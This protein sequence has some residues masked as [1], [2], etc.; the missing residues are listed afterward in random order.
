[1]ADVSSNNTRF[2]PV[3]YAGAG[4]RRIAIKATQSAGYTNPDHAVWTHLAHAARLSVTHY[5]WYSPNANT[6]AQYANLAKAILPVFLPGDSIAIDVEEPRYNKEPEV[7]YSVPLNTL[8][9]AIV[10][11][12]KHN[13]IIYMDEDWYT[14]VGIYVKT[15]EGRMWIAGYGPESPT[16]IDGHRLWAWQNTDGQ[17]GPGPHVTAGVGRCDCSL[18]NRRT[19]LADELRYRMRRS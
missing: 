4:H 3:I 17:Q 8:I 2:Q 15:P 19:A 13:P 11:L 1:M 9:D 16:V 5:H 12:A 6:A 10:K 18:L 7:L 14:K